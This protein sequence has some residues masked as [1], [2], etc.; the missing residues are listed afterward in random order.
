MYKLDLLS[1]SFKM[2]N[3]NLLSNL[4][5]WLFDIILNYPL[6]FP[7][8]HFKCTVSFLFFNRYISV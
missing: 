3:S 2:K 8:L 5:F 1:A 7:L 4:V 6:L